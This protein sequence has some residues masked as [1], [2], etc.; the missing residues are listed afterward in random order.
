VAVNWL[1]TSGSPQ[2]NDP[3]GAILYEGTSG[4][5]AFQ[6]SEASLGLTIQS[7][8]LTGDAISFLPPSGDTTGAT[9]LAR[10]T[11][12]FA[13]GIPVYLLP[14][15]YHVNGPIVWTSGASLIGVYSGTYPGPGGIPDN[16]PGI[17]VIHRVAGTN[18]DVIQVPDTVNYGR[19]ADFGID[20]N[21]LHN[22]AGYGI[23]V[24]DGAASQETQ[25]IMER[26]FIHDNPSTNIYL[27]FNR[28]ACTLLNCVAAF[29]ANGDGVTAIGSDTTIQNGIYGSNGR[30][31]INCG[32]T[33]TQNWAAFDNSAGVSNPNAADVIHI[34]GT[35]TYGNLVGIA[36]P[37]SC[38]N[39]MV[40]DNG[41]DRN[42][43]Q[44]LTV[45]DGYSNSIVGNAFHSNS[46][47]ANNTYGH[48]DLAAG[49]SEVAMSG[50]IFGPQDSGYPNVASYGV[51]TEAGI[52]PG[53]I[54]G[55][56][57]VL[58]PSATVNGLIS[59]AGANVS[60]SVVLSKGGAIIQGP[61]ATQEIIE[62][63][64][65]TGVTVFS[66]DS[67]GTFSVND[68]VGKFQAGLAGGNGHAAQ[69]ITANGDTI[70]NPG[71]TLLPLSPNNGYN[72]TIMQPGGED[73]QVVWLVN[74][75]GAATG[76]SITFAAAGVSNVALGAAAVVNPAQSM[77][78]VWDASTALWYSQQ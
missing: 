39:A 53:A 5:W 30:A 66:M 46:A 70:L 6:P 29:S 10:I 42:L 41:V 54:L 28:R 25:I 13:L 20:G 61:N 27:G 43:N 9:D 71:V 78:L 52:S 51:V 60:P 35:N 19:M 7:P 44:G 72:G 56:I 67:G 63:R 64:K 22:T 55:D 47:S 38:V 12:L 4:L 75:A 2:F 21:K 11:A 26:L 57:G 73:G 49:V 58:D 34:F 14:G 33:Q 3:V 45:W 65:S 48:V 18:Q 31:G 68:G 40:Q 37:Q 8:G 16:I 50:N 23:N 69:A 36:L 17:S 15:I 24:L 59:T 62:F 77:Q 76:F 74:I 1:T 32:T